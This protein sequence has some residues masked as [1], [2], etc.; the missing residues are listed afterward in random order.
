MYLH[1]ITYPFWML[2]VY[3]IIMYH[4]ILVCVFFW[5]GVGQFAK[6][7]TMVAANDGHHGRESKYARAKPQ[8]TSQ[9]FQLLAHLKEQ[10]NSMHPLSQRKPLLITCRDVSLVI[11]YIYILYTSK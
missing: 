10:S 1:I 5:G 7:L 4:P 3:S 8:S 2:T 9:M 11:I 6:Q